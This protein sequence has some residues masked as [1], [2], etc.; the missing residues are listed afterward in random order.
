MKRGI[1]QLLATILLL[2]SI[3][4]FLLLSIKTTI[5]FSNFTPE[6]QNAVNYLQGRDELLGD[7]TEAERAHMHDVQQ[8]FKKGN[9][10]FLMLS[11]AFILLFSLFHEKRAEIKKIIFFSGILITSIV[12]LI[13]IL[14]L[15]SFNTSFIFFHT[16]F[17]P[18]GNW[19]FPVDSLLI[20]IFP[21]EF[22]TKMSFLIFSQALGWGILFILI[23]LYFKYADQKRQS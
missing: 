10:L 22:F 13:L 2:C 12:I 20:Q 14:L 15:L 21:L 4:L 19:Q 23:S 16:I 9:A 18:Q 8:L 3:V 17:F 1:T 5:L 6:Q 7:Y 11:G